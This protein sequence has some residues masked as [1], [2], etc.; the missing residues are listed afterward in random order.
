LQSEFW[1]RINQNFRDRWVERYSKNRV[2]ELITKLGAPKQTRNWTL[3]GYPKN[4]TILIIAIWES[5]GYF[6]FVYNHQERNKDQFN[7]CNTLRSGQKVVKLSDEY[8]DDGQMT[9][10]QGW[11][12]TKK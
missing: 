1:Q 6:S 10:M 8:M 12:D 9:Y 7:H 5:K 4:R 3:S 11:S 2:N